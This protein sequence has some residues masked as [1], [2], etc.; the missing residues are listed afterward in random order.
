VS[1]VGWYL[2]GGGGRG[3]GSYLDMLSVSCLLGIQVKMLR[4][5]LNILN[6]YICLEFGKV[7]Q[8]GDEHTHTHTHTHTHYISCLFLKNH[9]CIDGI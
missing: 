7:Y 6:I 1:R 2:W 5:Q 4:K 8:P 3:W 9:Q